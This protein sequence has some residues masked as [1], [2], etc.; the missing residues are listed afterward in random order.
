MPNANRLKHQE[1]RLFIRECNSTSEAVSLATWLRH[2][3]SHMSRNTQLKTA[4]TA[5]Y[6]ES[7]EN[8]RC[9]NPSGRGVEMVS[10]GFR[11]S[12]PTWSHPSHLPYSRRFLFYFFRLLGW[13][14]P[15]IRS[16]SS[17]S[18]PPFRLPLADFCTPHGCTSR[19]H[20]IRSFCYHR[21]FMPHTYH[22]FIIS[23]LV[24]SL[25]TSKLFFGNGHL[26][27]SSSRLPVMICDLWFFFGYCNICKLFYH[28]FL[29]PSCVRAVFSNLLRHIINILALF[30]LFVAWSGRQVC[31]FSI[32]FFLFLP[33]LDLHVRHE[34]S[35]SWRFRWQVDAEWWKKKHNSNSWPNLARKQMGK[36]TRT[37]RTRRLERATTS[38][39]PK[40]RRAK[41]AWVE[42]MPIP[43]SAEK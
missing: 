1:Y 24:Y 27:F 26:F 15:S 10:M 17:C 14:C 6:L 38:G 31:R 9:P 37:R 30:H 21:L 16:G 2:L 41:P 39:R 8:Q 40:T 13:H 12:N 19:P 35:L 34:D 25:H 18:T 5:R 36:I 28:N 43:T 32:F 23:T 3:I 20:Y 42:E 33:F 11:E 4:I 22:R 29:L 7:P